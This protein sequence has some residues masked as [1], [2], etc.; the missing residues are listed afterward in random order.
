MN[1]CH[2]RTPQD[3]VCG[4]TNAVSYALLFFIPMFSQGSRS[5]IG[6]VRVTIKKQYSNLVSFLR[7]ICTLIS[8]FF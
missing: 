4:G 2:T 8:K 1:L 5:K 7:V 3:M 6:K